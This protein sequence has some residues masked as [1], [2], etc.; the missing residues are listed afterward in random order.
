M[1][2]ISV[3][4]LT[5]NSVNFIKPCLDSMFSQ[6]YNDFEV[7]LVDNGSND[8]TASFI[9]KNYLQVIL[10]ENKEN[11]GACKARNQGIDVSMGEWILTLDCDIILE[12]DFLSRAVEE[13]KNLPGD[14]GIIQPKI[15]KEDKKTI[16]STGIFLSL[17]RRFHDIGKGSSDSEEF[18][19]PKYVFGACSAAAFYNRRMLEEIKEASGYFDENF[20]FLVEDVDLAWRAKRKDWWVLYYPQAICYHV[21]NSASTSKSL[22]RYLCFRNRYLMIH[23]NETLVGK[24]KLFFL[25]FWYESARIIYI[26]LTTIPQIRLRRTLYEN[27]PLDLFL[28]AP[29]TDQSKRHL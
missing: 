10:I 14:V 2:K 24:I 23:K 9:K 13:I 8:A 27:R 29:D 22:R 19:R 21:G 1:A 4:I 20:F 28:M 15:L 16:Y 7:I 3:V 17:I 18:A 25:S 11:L 26:C 5:Y 6:D 12:N